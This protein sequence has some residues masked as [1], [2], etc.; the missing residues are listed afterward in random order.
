MYWEIMPKVKKK[1][2]K[3][4]QR[5]DKVRKRDERAESIERATQSTEI[6]SLGT[7]MPE[8]STARNDCDGTSRMSNSGELL[9]RNSSVA[10]SKNGNVPSAQAIVD[11][12]LQSQKDLA[13][14][15]NTK[16]ANNNESAAKTANDVCGDRS[17]VQLKYK[18]KRRQ[19][20]TE[21]KRR[22][23]SQTECRECERQYNRAIK[24]LAREEP[25][26]RG[27]ERECNKKSKQIA[28]KDHAYRDSER[29]CSRMSKQKARENPVN[30]IREQM[31]DIERKRTSRHKQHSRDDLI[32]NFHEEVAKGPVH[33]CCVCDQLW[34][35]HSVVRIQNNSLPDCNAVDVC[36]PDMRQSEGNN[37][38]CNTCLS[39]LKKKNIPPSST[40]NGMGFPEI[41][42]YLKDLHQV[43]W[44][45]VSPRT[46]FMNVFAAPRGGQK[47]IRG[48]VV[49][50]PCDTVNT[51]QGLPHSGNEQQTIQ[52]K[53]KRDLRYTNHVMS[54]NVR[55][56][57]VRE[58]A[59]YLVTHG[60]LFKDQGISFDKT[61]AENNELSNNIDVNE[62]SSLQIDTNVG[63]PCIDGRA[64]SSD[65]PGE[66]Q[67][68]CSDSNESLN[69][70]VREGQ[71]EF[72]TVIGV[73]E[74]Q[75]GCSHGD[76][77][78]NNAVKEEQMEFGAVAEPATKSDD[79]N[80]IEGVIEFRVITGEG[81]E[82]K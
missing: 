59:E 77:S 65:I 19:N 52:V 28:R 44:R 74:T 30:R 8:V 26:F 33:K 20:N 73:D 46:S 68:G 6:V 29:E 60:K 12:Y 40:A 50:V 66:H 76:G 79:G 36:V 42:Q 38:M 62:R 11:K 4:R 70:A 69:V 22:A 25:V 1:S 51:F 16:Y 67:T 82:N 61:W 24:R 78:F 64:I 49:N 9:S 13:R 47:K 18:D 80:A 72:G 34:Y 58:A 75:A 53:I 56:Y 14:R 10:G 31:P 35:R 17:S 32:N 43:E 41:P 63:E 54:Q 71:M 3:Q 2:D 21:S 81:D 45:L 48:N 7:S 27:G 55:P 57:K 15:Y 39:H 23:R 5:Q 37:L